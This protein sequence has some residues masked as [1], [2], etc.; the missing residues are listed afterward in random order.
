MDLKANNLSRRAAVKLLAAGA[1]SSLIG[2]NLNTDKSAS[3]KCEAIMNQRV[4]P[5]S[6][7]KIPVIGLGTWQTFDVSNNKTEL[8]PL[9]E[10]LNTLIQHGG[11][12]I[13]SSP[14]YG[15]S[16]KV[17]GQL[18]TELNIKNKIFEATKVWTSGY[19]EGLNQIEDSYQ[20]LQADP[21]E[22]LQVHNLLDWKTQIKTLYD[23]KSKGRVKYVGITHYHEGGYDLMEEV[24]KKEPIDFIQINYNL[25]VR[26]ANERLLPLAKDKGIAVLI[27]RP[28][29]GGSLFR[30]LKHQPLPDWAAEFDAN[31]WGQFFL[32]FI[33]ANEAVTCVIPGT[34]KPRHMKD[35]VQAGFGK[36]PTLAHQS[37]MIQLIDKI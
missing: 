1:S 35:N 21:I 18:T 30:K 19:Q 10:V 8:D 17:V 2:I 31:S 26:N 36:L 23:L 6:Q 37:K 29:E 27:N 24:M 14:M 9:K 28:Y 4:I 3:S 5:S 11:S 15:R 34:S 20:L 7:E 12:V 22:L 32:K 33:L 16:E 25:A 13:D